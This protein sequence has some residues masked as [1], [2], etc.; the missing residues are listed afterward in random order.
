MFLF[1]LQYSAALFCG[2]CFDTLPHVFPCD[3]H[4]FLLKVNAILSN[5]AEA[6]VT[7][8]T[9]HLS[10]SPSLMLPVFILSCSGFYHLFLHIDNCTSF[11]GIYVLPQPSISLIKVFTQVTLHLFLFILQYSADLPLLCDL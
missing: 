2:L 3:Q 7:S 4:S 5:T 8:P 11:L 9:C 1:L 6:C 10:L